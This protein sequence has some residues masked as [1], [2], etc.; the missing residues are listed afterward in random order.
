VGR[1]MPPE[2]R[3]P[4]DLIEEGREIPTPRVLAMHEG[5]RRVRKT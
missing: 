5:K 1:V 4:G 3:I 2:Q